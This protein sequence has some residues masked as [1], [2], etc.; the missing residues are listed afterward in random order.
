MFIGYKVIFEVVL[1]CFAQYCQFYNCLLQEKTTVL[2]TI[3]PTRD[4]LA[5][6]VGYQRLPEDQMRKVKQLKD[7]LESVLM[8]DP[9]KRISINAALTHPFIQEK[10]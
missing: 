10:I 9:A 5:E 2:S 1:N 7:L 8:L 4:L 6:L 3:S